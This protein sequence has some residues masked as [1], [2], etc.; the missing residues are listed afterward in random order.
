MKVRN[1]DAETSTIAQGKSADMY[2]HK[3]GKRQYRRPTDVN[4]K[5]SIYRM[6]YENN[7]LF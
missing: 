1:I 4:D 7:Q 3:K 2:V 5:E 6:I